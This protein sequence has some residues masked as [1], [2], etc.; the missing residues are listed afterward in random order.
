MSDTDYD[1]FKRARQHK[2][3]TNGENDAAPLPIWT[4]NTIREMPPPS[5]VLPGLIPAKQKTLILAP[6]AAS[7]PRPQ[8]RCPVP[9]PTATPS[10]ASRPT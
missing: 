10:P 4:L 1:D 5:W 6:P 8:S 3:K 9:S 7:S 2:G